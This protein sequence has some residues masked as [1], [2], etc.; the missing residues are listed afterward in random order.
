MPPIRRQE[1]RMKRSPAAALP[2]AAI[3]ALLIAGCGSSSKS[4]TSSYATGGAASATSATGAS[5]TASAVTVTVVSVGGKL[6]TILAA[7][8]DKRTVYL[9]EGDHGSTSACSGACVQTWPAVTT[10]GAAAAGAG[11]NAALVGTIARADGSK[12][13]TY[14][15]HPLYFFAGDSAS[16]EAKGEGSKAFGAG[17]YV[18]APTGKKIDLS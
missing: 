17:W 16:G 11:T 9:F 13:V 3:A 12:Q 5:G 4:S 10:S 6:G 1:K 2:V 8:P 14:H 18:L 7:G 15:G